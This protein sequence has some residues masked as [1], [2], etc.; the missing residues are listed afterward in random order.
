MVMNYCNC[1]HYLKHPED[2]KPPAMVSFRGRYPSE[3]SSA[4]VDVDKVE[5]SLFCAVG[6]D[7]QNQHSS[8]FVRP[9][10]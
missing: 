7:L 6:V 2:Q 3:K 8:Y 4:A 10:S 1:L 9:Y 5:R